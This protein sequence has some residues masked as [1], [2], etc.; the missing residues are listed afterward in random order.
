MHSGVKRPFAVWKEVKLKVDDGKKFDYTFDY[1]A[2]EVRDNNDLTPVGAPS[3]FEVM[4][5]STSGGNR[6]KRTTIAQCFEDLL[7][8]NPHDG[9]GINYRQVWGRMISQFFVKSIVATAWSGRTFWIIQDSLLDYI[10]AST[11]F[12]GTRFASDSA[13]EVNLVSLGYESPDGSRSLYPQKISLFSGPIGADVSDSFYSILTAP[14]LP[15]LS[16]LQRLLSIRAPVAKF[17]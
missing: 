10:E 3:I 4:T 6:A 1:V 8:G 17:L 9:P 7:K 14:L 12:R 2:S 13:S 15:D 16:L 5:S 11:G